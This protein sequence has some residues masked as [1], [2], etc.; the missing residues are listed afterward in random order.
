MRRGLHRATACAVATSLCAFLIAQVA[1]AAD[2]P[3]TAEPVDYVRVCDAFGSGF[4]HVPGTETC[5]RIQGRVR[6]DYR[7]YGSN[8]AYGGPG[9][10]SNAADGY[11]FRARA[12]LYQDSRTNTEYGLLRT[13]SE[14]WFTTDTNAPN[15]A[16]FIRN[17]F[18]Q[19]A[20]LTAGRASSFYDLYFGDTYNTV[21]KMSGMGDPDFAANLLAYTARFGPGLSASLS[22]EDGVY[23]KLGVQ[24][25]AATHT[26]S[27]NKI[28]DFIANVKL[29]QDWGAAQLMAATHE[30]RIGRGGGQSDLGYAVGAGVILNLPMLAKG[31][32]IG[33]QGGYSD[34]AL[35]YVARNAV[36]P[37]VVDGVI[38]N[39]KLKLVSAWAIGAS[40]VH[41][42]TPEWSSALGAAYLDVD[43]PNPGTDFS[44]IDLQANLVFRPVK[45]LQI[46]GEVEWKSV[47]PDRGDDRSGLVGMIRVQRDF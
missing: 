41:N 30:V 9:F 32:R 42:W 17:A 21:F 22:M 27:G 16:V 24:G 18:I 3:M 37:S 45:G 43:A 39:G 23:R 20:G 5:F 33:I 1:A 14:I 10:Y 31:D 47:Q 26:Q 7:L 13:Y 29:E 4:L 35:Q 44:N 34:G 25:P 36:G 15:T 12:Y 6:A 2:A 8:R 46:G 38:Q 28:P 11:V 40:G 19:F